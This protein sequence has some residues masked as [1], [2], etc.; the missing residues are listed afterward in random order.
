[1]R[2]SVTAVQVL[3]VEKRRL[4][5]KHYVYVIQVTWDDGSV[6]TINRRYS[7]FFDLQTSLLETFPEEGGQLNPDERTI[8]FLPGKKYFGRSHIREVA[9]KRLGPIDKY[10]KLLI[11][12][13]PKISRCHVVLTFFEATA[14]DLLPKSKDKKPGETKISKPKLLEEYEVIFEYKKQAKDQ[15]DLKV[16]QSVQVIEK[17]ETGWWLVNTD[18]EEGYAPGTFLKKTDGQE[19][20]QMITCNGEKYTCTQVYTAEGSDDHTLNVGDE[21]EVLQKSLDGWWW[22]RFNGKIGWA[23]ATCLKAAGSSTAPRGNIPVEIVSNL[24]D[25]SKLLKGKSP[26]TNPTTT[27]PPSAPQRPHST[28]E[29]DT[30]S[31]YVS[32]YESDD[33]E[34]LE[35]NHYEHISS[36]YGNTS[37]TL[38]PPRQNTV[39][40]LPVEVSAEE[41]RTKFITSAPYVDSVGD[42]ISFSAGQEVEVQQKT[43]S[44]WYYIQIGSEF[45]WAPSSYLEEISSDETDSTVTFNK[46]SDDD[47]ED[48]ET[49]D[50]D[51][52]DDT[53]TMSPAKKIQEILAFKQPSSQSSSNSQPS[54]PVPN[55]DKSFEEVKPPLPSVDPSAQSVA[56]GLARKTAI[57]RPNSIPPAPPKRLDIPA[58]HPPLPAMPPLPSKI[59]SQIPLPP[60]PS[61]PNSKRQ[62]VSS[63]PQSGK[64]SAIVHP[65]PTSPPPPP[66][67]PHPSRPLPVASAEPVKE[68]NNGSGG[69]LATELQSRLAKLKAN[70]DSD[71]SQSNQ[72][73]QLLTTKEK[74]G[75]KTKGFAGNNPKVVETKDFK[76]PRPLPLIPPVQRSDDN[77]KG[78]PVVLPASNNNSLPPSEKTDTQQISSSSP[79]TC[80]VP[81]SLPMASNCRGLALLQRQKEKF[82]KENEE[83]ESGCKASNKN[84]ESEP[85]VSNL[86]NNFESSAS[87]TT[88]LDSKPAQPAKVPLKPIHKVKPTT[89]PVKPKVSPS[90]PKLGTVINANRN[91]S[92]TTIANKG[93]KF[94]G[95]NQASPTKF[96]ATKVEQSKSKQTQEQIIPSPT[97]LTPMHIK[98][99]PDSNL[100]NNSMVDSSSVKRP[101]QKSSKST[102]R[103]YKASSVYI[104]ESEGEVSFEKGVNVDVI[105]KHESGWWLVQVGNE[106]GWAPSNHIVEVK[107]PPPSKPLPPN[108]PLPKL[109]SNLSTDDSNRTAHPVIHNTNQKDFSSSSECNSPSHSE[110]N[111]RNHTLNNNNT[112]KEVIA[113]GDESLSDDASLDGCLFM[114]VSDFSA[115]EDSEISFEQGMHLKVL[116]S[117][118][119]DW[120]HV[121]L[122]S[123]EDGWAPASCIAPLQDV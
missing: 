40:N 62:S 29:I 5:S 19:E 88:Q 42:G 56:A 7:N 93:N 4:P 73:P 115:F 49:T 31:N 123:G 84:L 103:L 15:V 76:K 50:D 38:P 22:V 78:H 51:D 116:D 23:P 8:P 25:V 120:W 121:M 53:V 108:K 83:S 69:D 43:D 47:E 66:N 37:H 45:G 39:E 33:Y 16:G 30:E 90:K 98:S 102:D 10:C 82:M 113:V 77:Q 92:T 48:Y 85:K 34:D 6:I 2:K 104:A 26:T 89:I 44:G 35:E 111:S 86:R 12:L 18:Y 114:A 55:M 79:N 72:K 27:K 32:V 11:E 95:S 28:S 74:P 91:D 9:E 112:D 107:P 100:N 75:V 60:L 20:E 119:T 21:V 57:K 41:R 14:D 70:F 109:P 17:Y 67:R 63:V 101:T 97:N 80:A 3:G 65:R 68:I 106:E 59:N 94:G 58:E 122:Q 52:D 36:V 118:D 46:E 71:S 117:S 61:P 24:S 110:K 54:S 13:D 96:S 64:T 81:K 1:M 105:E 99:D 87:S